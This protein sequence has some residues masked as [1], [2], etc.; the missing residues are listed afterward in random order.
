MDDFRKELTAELEAQTPGSSATY[1]G[2]VTEAYDAVWTVALALRA[3]DQL[4]KKVRQPPFPLPFPFPPPKKNSLVRA[5]FGC[6]ITV[7]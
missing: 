1:G 4:W 6:S 7:A 5:I 2:H 3:A